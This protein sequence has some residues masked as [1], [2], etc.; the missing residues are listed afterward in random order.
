VTILAGGWPAGPRSRQGVE[1]VVGVGG[2]L[3]RPRRADLDSLLVTV[4]QA[5]AEA[6]A[7][8]ARHG[9]DHQAGRDVAAWR[10]LFLKAAD[11]LQAT[12]DSCGPD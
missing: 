8:L 2:H 7:R 1:A 5:Q 9:A 12:R 11:D 4:R 10:A 3:G 6:D